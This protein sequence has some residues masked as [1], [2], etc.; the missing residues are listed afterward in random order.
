[1]KTLLYI[2]MIS[3]ILLCPVL[4]TNAQTSKVELNQIE[5]IRQFAGTWKSE[6]GKDTTVIGVNTQFGSG[7]DCIS[8]ILTKGK[9][10][11][12]VKQLYGY[13][14]KNDKFIIAELIKSSP[15][16]ELCATW[17][18]SEHSGEMVLYQDISNPE[19]AVFKWRFEFKSPDII[20][21]TALK[22]NVVYKIITIARIK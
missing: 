4:R 13:D 7:L 2:I 8:Q 16:I 15:V 12:S 9:V 10:L 1:M 3:L 21:Q 22:N 19:K 6:I 5:L 14:M 20:V 11:E 17:F 18:T